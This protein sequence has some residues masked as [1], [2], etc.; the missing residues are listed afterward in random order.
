[1]TTFFVSRH[2]GA[3]DW[4]MDRSLEYDRL[5]TH[6]EPSEVAAGDVVIGTLPVNLAAEISAQG[7][8]Y[9]HLSLRL[10]PELRGIE[11]SADELKG[12]DAVLEEFRVE[13]VGFWGERSLE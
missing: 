3:R 4:A 8:T 11:L 1:M 7:A 6:L 9:V 2:P 5:V 13:R 12:M 10:P